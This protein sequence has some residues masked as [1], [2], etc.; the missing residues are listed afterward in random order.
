MIVSNS[1]LEPNYSGDKEVIA[2]DLL[3]TLWAI[4]SPYNNNN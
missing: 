1:Q 3:T 4:Q 2:S